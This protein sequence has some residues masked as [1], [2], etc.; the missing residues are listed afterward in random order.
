M[1]TRTGR[2]ILEESEDSSWIV[3]D[4]RNLSIVDEEIRS[5]REIWSIISS[6][7]DEFIRILLRHLVSERFAAMAQEERS[8]KE[9]GRSNVDEPEKRRACNSSKRHR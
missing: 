8:R 4:K 5:G 2:I 1:R 6:Q 9:R 7:D 3:H